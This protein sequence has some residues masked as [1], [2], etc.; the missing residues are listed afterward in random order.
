MKLRNL[1]YMTLCLLSLAVVSCEEDANN[2]EYDP[3]Y[4]RLFRPTKLSVAETEPTAVMLS[5]QGV[6]DATKYIFEFSEGDSLEFNNI[7]RTVEILA[8]TLTPYQEATSIVQT[9]FHTYFEDLNGTTRYSARVKAVNG[10]NGMESGFIGVCFDTPAE[11][12]FTTIVPGVQDATLNW[13]ADKKA[14]HIK[15]GEI[16]TSMGEDGTETRDTLWMN[17]VTLNES[18]AGTVTVSGLKPGTTYFAQI[19]NEHALR[20]S[21]KFRTLGASVGASIVVQP[22]DDVN[23]LLTEAAAQGVVTLIFE[24]GKSYDV[25][26]VKV[27]E[28]ITGLYMAGSIVN[29]ELANI[30]LKKFSFNAPMSYFTCQ[31]VK[32]DNDMQTNFMIEINNANA[33]ENIVFEGCYICNIPR[34][35]VRTNTGDAVMNRISI[36]NCILKNIGTNGYG[37]FN[38]G[39]LGG[40][41]LLNISKSTMID[42]GDQLMDVRLIIGEININQCTFCNYNIGMGKWLRLDKQPS[43]ISVTNMIFTGDN[44]GSKMNSGNSDYSAWLDFSGCYTTSDFLQNTRPFTNAKVL[45]MTSEELFVDPRNDDFHFKEGVDFTGDG[46]AGDPRWWTE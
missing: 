13:E 23:A 10:R 1:F 27:P 4:E 32:I 25:G 18:M 41:Q 26:E 45:D 37:C 16:A 20:G 9:V 6:T 19:Y 38:F 7:V 42:F 17:D 39:K 34:S 11:Q 35:L 28:G 46:V 22:G 29:G 21:Y 30:R 15:L 14:T 5:Y 2:W 43:S 24:G 44:K 12:I 8:D 31:Y 36:D 33:P 40:L 3:S